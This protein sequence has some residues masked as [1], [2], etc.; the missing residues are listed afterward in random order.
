MG[1]ILC[2]GEL[3]I[4]A[5]ADEA[6]GEEAKVSRRDCASGKED[7]MEA[8]QRNGADEIGRERCAK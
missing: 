2:D 1:W 5:G 4:A 6:G 7:G 3:I 8:A